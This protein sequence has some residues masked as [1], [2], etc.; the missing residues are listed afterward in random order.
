MENSQQIWTIIIIVAAAGYALWRLFQ[1]FRGKGDPC[2]CCDLKK[3][4]QKFCQSKEK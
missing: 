1:A 4:C 2:Q 3:N